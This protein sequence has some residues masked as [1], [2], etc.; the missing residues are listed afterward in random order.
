MPDISTTLRRLRR[1]PRVERIENL[2]KLARAE[3]P[4]S[5]R[6]NELEAALKFEMTAQLRKEARAA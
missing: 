4:R 2:Q 5:V 3:K 1:L 6:R